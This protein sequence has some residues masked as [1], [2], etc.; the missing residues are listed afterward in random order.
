[1]RCGGSRP[2]RGEERKVQGA[3][4]RAGGGR[5]AGREVVVAED[6]FHGSPKWA[7]DPVSGYDVSK[8]GCQWGA[9]IPDIAPGGEEGPTEKYSS[10]R[11]LSLNH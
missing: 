10:L 8:V 4:H 3:G 2:P 1:M 7:M 5:R 6:T 9:L 11:T